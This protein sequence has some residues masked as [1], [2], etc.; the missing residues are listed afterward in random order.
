MGGTAVSNVIESIGALE[1]NHASVLLSDGR[2]EA[3]AVDVGPTA[4]VTANHP[5]TYCPRIDDGALEASAGSAMMTPSIQVCV[6]PRCGRIDDG[7]LETAAAMTASPSFDTVCG[8][9]MG[10]RCFRR[11]DDSTN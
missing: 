6:T 9:T 2:L 10:P 4:T 3:T 7:E 8:S 11:I 5:F 1:L